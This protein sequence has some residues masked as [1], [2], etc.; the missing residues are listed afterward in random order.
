MIQK[1][2][3]LSAIAH[4]QVRLT[5]RLD[6][7][8]AVSNRFS[9]ARVLIFLGGFV[10]VSA[11]YFLAGVW[12][13]VLLLLATIT[14]FLVV[15]VRH[16]R[17]DA[18]IRRLE[19]LR[20]FKE[21]QLARANVVWRDLPAAQV[22]TA[23]PEHPFQSD[24]DL[25]GDYG[26]HRLLDTTATTGGRD[27]LLQWLSETD[28]QAEAIAARQAL[29]AELVPRS[30]FRL[31]LW[32]E[33]HAT[34]ET[35][36]WRPA[37]LLTWLD[38]HEQPTRMRPRLMLLT[39]LAAFNAIAFLGAWLGWFGP[40]WQISV[41]LYLIIYFAISQPA[42]TVFREATSLQAAIEQFTA[43]VTHVE[44]FGYGEAPKLRA[45]CAPLVDAA[46]RPSALLGK[47]KTVAAATGIQGNPI[48]WLLLNIVV[49]WDYFFAFQ[50]H[51]HKRAIAAHAPEWLAIWAELEALS[52]LANLGYLNPHYVQPVISAAD[53]LHAGESP[54]FRATQL[55]HP[56][57]PE[58]GPETNTE[59]GK[60]RNDF[61]LATLGDVVILTGSNMAGKSTFLRTVGVN[62]ALAYAGGM[63]DARQLDTAL[64]RLFTCIKVSDSVADGI[65]YFY[66]EVRRLKGLLVAL[67]EADPRPLFFLIDEIFRGTNNRER[68][69]GSQAYVDTLVGRQGVGLISTHDLEMVK[70][71]EQLARVSNFHFRDDIVDGRMSFDYKLRPGPCPTTNALKIMELEG[72]PTGL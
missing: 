52:A 49:P 9:W 33:A 25:V 59:S 56:L 51:R 1:A 26:L 43:V 10:G 5:A 65:S 55:G 16:R 29:V 23:Q 63:V 62:L 15:L 53:T 70:L 20:T 34:G 2:T 17:V 22:T 28:P 44:S 24:L 57:L 7:L 13:F 18:M 64:F 50:L 38:Q 66:A 47:V 35:T 45:L 3:R 42:R 54:L 41:P 31:R 71:A 36:R 67:D 30:L 19:L 4:Q 11:L 72:L 60:V 32:V 61:Q 46:Q 40:I 69:Q 39:A 12:P 48:I 6:A 68:L 27:L 37:D 21:E 14:L 58:T 8:R